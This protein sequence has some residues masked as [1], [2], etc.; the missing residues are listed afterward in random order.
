MT[1]ISAARWKKHAKHFRESVAHYE[2]E[3]KKPLNKFWREWHEMH[4]LSARETVKMAERFAE[5]AKEREADDLAD[6]Q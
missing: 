1:H 2:R 3:L 4:L 5:Q 6:I